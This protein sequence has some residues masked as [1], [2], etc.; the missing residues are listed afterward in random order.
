MLNL[1]LYHKYSKSCGDLED[2]VWWGLSWRQDSATI[3]RRRPRW[4]GVVMLSCGDGGGSGVMKRR[5]WCSWG[6]WRTREGVDIVVSRCRYGPRSE[7]A[8]GGEAVM[9]FWSDRRWRCFGDEVWWA[10]S[11]EQRWG[12]WGVKDAGVGL[13]KSKVVKRED[14][15]TLAST[16]GVEVIGRD[17]GGEVLEVKSRWD[18]YEVVSVEVA[19]SN[20]DL[21]AS[22]VVW[23]ACGGRLETG[24]G[25][26][27]IWEE[28]DG[29]VF[30][31]N[32]QFFLFFSKAKTK[33]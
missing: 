12:G 20:R 26:W 5:L 13:A 32:F 22:V 28:G 4:R 31:G 16:R 19:N 25:L 1:V 15:Q 11:V 18:C 8:V 29:R 10:R 21:M 30:R 23:L 6:H 33:D 14:E 2:L 3:S 24:L 17:L 27:C 7:G 9:W